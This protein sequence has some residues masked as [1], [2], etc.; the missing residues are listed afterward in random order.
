M[1]K[2][3]IFTLGIVLSASAAHAQEKRGYIEGAA[4]FTS[5]TDSTTSNA[6]GE[7]AFKVAPKLM[8]FGNLGR[9]NDLTSSSIQNS[10]NNAVTALS[11]NNDL[12]VTGEAKIPAWYTLGGAKFQMLNHTPITPFVMGGIGW[13][14]LNPSVHFLYDSGTTLSGNDAVAGDDL[15][16][17]IES[18]GLFTAPTPSNAFMFRTGGGVQVPLG[19]HLLSSVGYTY[20]RISADTP[21]NAQDVTFGLGVR[22]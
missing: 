9:L 17:D 14:R 12:T 15:T 21:I 3:L 5:L 4:G 16:P 11:T 8:V 13:A 19:K 20:S 22:F 6:S 2:A 10:I 18:N 1:R 7:V